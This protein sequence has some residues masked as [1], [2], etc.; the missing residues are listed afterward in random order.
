V[1][2]RENSQPGGVFEGDQAR[3]LY[4]LFNGASARS[5]H[6]KVAAS[7]PGFSSPSS[8]ATG[9]LS[10]KRPGI[11]PGAVLDK[12]APGSMKRTSSNSDEA[13]PVA[14]AVAVPVPAPVAAAARVVT[15]AANESASS[16]YHNSS[17]DTP[18]LYVPSSSLDHAGTNTPIH[19]LTV[20]ITHHPFLI[21]SI[22][23]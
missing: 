13:P 8:N 19:L 1:P 22:I 5:R 18:E 6:A 9:W 21:T 14:V 15:P 20:I 11:S 10:T 7:S 12:G 23:P 16:S 3:K 2:K 17:S 4:P